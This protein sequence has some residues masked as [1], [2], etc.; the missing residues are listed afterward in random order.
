MDQWKRMED[1]EI[2]PYNYRHLILD[3]GGK[4]HVG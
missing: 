1:P 3:K 2:N 4:K